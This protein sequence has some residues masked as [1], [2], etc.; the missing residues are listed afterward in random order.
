MHYVGLIHNVFNQR[1]FTLKFFNETTSDYIQFISMFLEIIGITLAYIE[2]RYKPLANRIEAKILAEESR[3]RNFASR[4]I[5]NKI[6]VT[7][8]TIF[9]FFVFF[10][11]IPYL[12]GFFDRIVPEKWNHILVWGIRSTLPVIILFITGICVVVFGDFIVWLNA[13]SNGH[14]IGALGVVVTFLGLLG[15]TYQVITIMTR[16]QP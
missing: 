8:A 14:A 16:V 5:E 13:F 3:I 7:L 15:E 10:F 12:V 6:F 11:D 1:T 4:L 9:F 2:I